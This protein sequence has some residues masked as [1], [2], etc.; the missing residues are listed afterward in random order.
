MKKTLVLILSLL[1]ISS[2][3]FAAVGKETKGPFGYNLNDDINRAPGETPIAKLNDKSN[4]DNAEE[5]QVPKFYA[6]GNNEWES[7][8]S[9]YPNATMSSAIT[10]YKHGNYSG[11][12]QE[13][14][15]LSKKDPYNPLLLYYL[16]MTYTQVGNKQ[17]AI[18]AYEAV[19]NMHS[20]PTLTTYATKGRDC[21]SGGPTCHEEEGI[22]IEDDLDR[23][24]NS[25]YGNGLSDELNQQMKEQ[26]LRNIEKRIKAKDVLEDADMENIHKFDRKKSD[27]D[28]I[29]KEKLA[30]ADDSSVSNEDVLSAIETLK[31]AGVTV[32]INP[33]QTQMP[34]NDEYAQLSMMLGNNNYNNNNSMMNMLPMLMTQNKGQIDPQVIQSMMMNSMLPDFTFND[35][36]D[37]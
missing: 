25:P 9:Y 17:Q 13:F 2:S 19:I 16:G 37:Y 3:A 11:A 20:N 23:F 21:L 33:Y 24:V 28:D 34:M 32:S 35:K 7:A 10:K 5:Q 12:L 31:K 14:I 30:M 8:A 36:K 4:K 27:A 6:N 26:Q 29:N 1:F 15:S 22:K 18:N